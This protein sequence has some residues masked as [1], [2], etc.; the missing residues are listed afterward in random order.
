MESGPSRVNAP[1]EGPV[2]PR[3]RR[4]LSR[5]KA[6]GEVSGVEALSPRLPEV[7]DSE[8]SGIWNLVPIVQSYQDDRAHRALSTACFPYFGL[9]DSP[10]NTDIS[11]SNSDPEY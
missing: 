9:P 7:K 2:I 10:A 5:T 8:K 11:D 1:L 6:S 4:S 3:S